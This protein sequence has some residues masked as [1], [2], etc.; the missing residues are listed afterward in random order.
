MGDLNSARIRK[1]SAECDALHYAMGWETKDMDKPQI[2]ISSTYGDSH[3]GSNHLQR[4]VEQAE[5][6]VFAGGGA[7]GKYYITDICDGVCQGSEGMRYSL[8]SRDVIASMMEIHALARPVDGVLCTSSC[9]KSLPAQLLGIARISLPAVIVPG[10]SMAAGAGFSSC[11]YMWEA[12]IK[13]NNGEMSREEY[14][15]LAQVSCPSSGACQAVGTASTMQIMAEALGLTLPGA[16]L[17]PVS[18]SALPQM[19]KASGECIVRLVKDGVGLKDIVTRASV[20]NAIAVHAAVCGSANAVMHL[21][22]FAR[23]LGYDISLED[24]D[25]I[26]RQ[27][28]VIVN[29]APNGRYPTEWLWYAGG[30]AGVMCRIR[31]HLDLDVLTVT[32]KKLG[33]VLDEFEASQSYKARQGY[34]TNMGLTAEDIIRPLSDPVFPEGGLAVLRGNLCPGG[35]LIKHAA[36]VEQMRVHQGPAYIFDDEDMAIAAVLGGAI[37]PGGFIIIRYQGPAAKGMPEMFRIS[38][39]INKRPALASTTAVLTDGRYSGFTL[40]PAIGYAS[41]EAYNG[42]PLALVKQGDLIRLDIPARRLDL[43]GEGGQELSAEAAD[44]LLEARKAAW[45]RP[46]IPVRKGIL[47]VYRKLIANPLDGDRLN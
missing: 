3:P 7:P 42:G 5:H 8:L 13:L 30:A 6:G 32:G 33:Q 44:A 11:D 35:A 45:T 9:D 47:N 10:G 16:A 39:A 14:D 38:D 2:M 27:V 19:A 21:T 17:I 1:I 36:V 26:Q 31:E 20:C 25:R 12:Q 34:L 41:P 46:D 24:F 18:N 22:A 4:L 15:A 29:A 40:G 43:V 37:P 23:E 28:P